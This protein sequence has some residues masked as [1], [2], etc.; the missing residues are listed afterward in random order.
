[1][2]RPD[3]PGACIRFIALGIDF[4]LYMIIYAMF[5]LLLVA[6]V[7][8]GLIGKGMIATLT[9]TPIIPIVFFI[10]LFLYFVIFDAVFA[11][12]IGKR[13]CKIKVV[14]SDYCNISIQRSLLR[15]GVSFVLGPC[16]GIC[17]IPYILSADGECL[18]DRVSS[19]M[20]VF[21]VTGSQV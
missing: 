17:F 15:T 8:G 20:V 11:G 18:H 1:M 12:T 9:N 16:F 5:V 6:G 10:L 21:A 3:Y 7:K 4:V 14:G 2:K 19:T 13:I